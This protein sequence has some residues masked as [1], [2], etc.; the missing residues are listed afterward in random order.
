MDQ[1]AVTQND[2]PI[3]VDLEQPTTTITQDNTAP[4]NKS[5]LDEN[6]LTE[7]LSTYINKKNS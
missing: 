3:E 7:V 4:P 6:D 2:I 5:D 1:E